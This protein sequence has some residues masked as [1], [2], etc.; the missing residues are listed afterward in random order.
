M[1]IETFL[2]DSRLAD[3][4]PAVIAGG[5]ELQDLID[6]DDDTLLRLFGGKIANVERLRREAVKLTAKPGAGFPAADTRRPS[7]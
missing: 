6:S 1:N 5:Y 3:Y 7:L 2:Q 4:I